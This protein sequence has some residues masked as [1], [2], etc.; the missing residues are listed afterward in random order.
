MGH[1]SK[2]GAIL[3]RFFFGGPAPRLIW[4]R[5]A[6]TL[7]LEENCLTLV[8]P[9]PVL[10]RP[11]LSDICESPWARPSGRVIV[12]PIQGIGLTRPS[13]ILPNIYKIARLV[14]FCGSDTWISMLFPS[15]LLFCIFKV[16]NRARRVVQRDIVP[17]AYEDGHI[18]INSYIITLWLIGS[19]N[20]VFIL[21]SVVMYLFNYS[22]QGHTYAIAWKC[23]FIMVEITKQI[24]Y[25][26]ATWGG[27]PLIYRFVW[28]LLTWV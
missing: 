27:I 14:C 24:Y 26:Y 2:S 17:R 18:C 21:Y 7:E 9:I 20:L 8:K 19:Y 16:P 12:C 3:I 5:V 22:A 13:N 10:L 15:F 6:N 25:R 23:E 1:L 11:A 28:F 4:F